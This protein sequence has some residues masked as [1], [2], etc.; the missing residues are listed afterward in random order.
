MTLGG[1]VLRRLLALV[2]IVLPI[3]GW[4]AGKKRRVIVWTLLVV[5]YVT[6]R[7]LEGVVR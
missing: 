6:L 4:R 7:G 5:L 3:A 2:P 1:Y